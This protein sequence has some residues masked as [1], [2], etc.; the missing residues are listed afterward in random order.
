MDD[1]FLRAISLDQVVY[2]IG[3][4]LHPLSIKDQII[5][6]QLFVR[7]AF[8][9]KIIRAS[10]AAPGAN[11]SPPL[12][13]VGG[14][15]AGVVVTMEAARWGVPVVLIEKNSDPFPRQRKCGTRR[16]DPTQYDWP[17][18]HWASGCYP[19][20]SFAYPCP[21]PWGQ[22][23]ISSLLAAAWEAKFLTFVS[24][25][26]PMHGWSVTRYFGY[27]FISY[28]WNASPPARV[29]VVLQRDA[30][31]RPGLPQAPPYVDACATLNATGFGEERIKASKTVGVEFW[32]SDYLSL[33]NLNLSAKGVKPEVLI[34]GGGDGALQDYLRVVTRPDLQWARPI[35]EACGIPR[36]VEA[37]IRE[38]QDAVDRQFKW[39][40][41]AGHDHEPLQ[42]LHKR[43]AMAV[44]R[45]LSDSNV[46]TRLALVV[47]DPL[48]NVLLVYPCTH[49]GPVYAL[50]RFLVMLLAR[51]FKRHHFPH[52]RS[53]L[54]GGFKLDQVVGCGTH[55]CRGDWMHCY[56]E[57]HS[58]TL[59]RADCAL[60]SLAGQPRTGTANVVVIRHGVALPPSS[61]LSA[62]GKPA[63][64]RHI[65]PYGL[66]P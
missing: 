31:A 12:V 46:Q 1:P 35:Y 58:F 7:R 32:A 13:V 29:R 8:E 44:T 38:D 57:P 37:Q 3:G 17:A 65:L 47:R 48:P 2:S 63:Q 25:D 42:W 40:Y 56:G 24:Q 39:G 27:R 53:T 55:K 30:D 36:R 16:L 60:R 59:G 61:L 9:Q 21:L 26:C 64:R 28:E 6:A 66:L 10:S 52:L 49:F 19:F 15:V 18:R 22:P 41:H 45:A 51:F 20:S 33:P 14:G 50:N 4:F 62:S 11:G 54:A 23:E 43:C 5:R 34:S